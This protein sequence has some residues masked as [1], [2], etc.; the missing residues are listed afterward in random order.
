MKQ[1]FVKLFLHDI[2]RIHGVSESAIELLVF[3]V[4]N[5]KSDNYFVTQISMLDKMTS[6]LGKSVKTIRALIT[7]L[8]KTDLIIRVA[9]NV[10]MV[11]P[12]IAAIGDENMVNNKR[13]LFM[14]IR[15][16]Q[17]GSVRNIS[18]GYEDTQQPHDSNI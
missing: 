14:H 10:Y 18:T 13:S 8:V 5:M 16:E 12:Y 15:Y 3:I 17:C 1:R 7:E 2:A 9:S 6:K 11:N 4:A